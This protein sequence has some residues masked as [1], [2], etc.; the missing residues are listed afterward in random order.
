M[1]A[2]RGQK[3]TTVTVGD[4]PPRLV[5][6][7]REDEYISGMFKDLFHSDCLFRFSAVTHCNTSASSYYDIVP[8]KRGMDG[9][10]ICIS[11]F[12][13]TQNSSLRSSVERGLPNPQPSPHLL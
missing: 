9:T 5:P 6:V 10:G 8:M 4:G 13:R 2:P 7:D 11:F 3:S 12:M 1:K